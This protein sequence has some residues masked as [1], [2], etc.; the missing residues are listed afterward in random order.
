MC[1]EGHGTGKTHEG[2]PSDPV[3]RA[4]RLSV[5]APVVAPHQSIPDVLPPPLGLDVAVQRQDHPGRERARL[6][7]Q[8]RVRVEAPSDG[9]EA[10]DVAGRLKALAFR[11]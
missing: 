8:R 4:D 6:V 11:L 2:D 1:V 3:P 10:Q 9:G 5:A 7:P